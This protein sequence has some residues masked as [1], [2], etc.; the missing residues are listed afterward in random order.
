MNS[1]HIGQGT[2]SMSYKVVAFNKEIVV[3]LNPGIYRLDLDSCTGKTYLFKLISGMVAMGENVAAIRYVGG[4][5]NAITVVGSINENTKLVIIDR[6][7]MYPDGCEVLQKAFGCKQ[8]IVLIDL[9]GFT[10]DT[11][12]VRMGMAEMKVTEGQILVGQ[13]IL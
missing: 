2:T 11:R 5:D 9:K 12:H 13:G 7:D 1:K 8:A 4:P 3:S 10:P 6:G